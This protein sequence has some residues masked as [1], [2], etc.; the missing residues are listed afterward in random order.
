MTYFAYCQ[1][2]NQPRSKVLT[3]VSLPEGAS[4]E[5]IEDAAQ[6]KL[7]RRARVIAW[8]TRWWEWIEVLK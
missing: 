5:M 4:L 3:H 6:K 1:L 7:M 2:I 8:T